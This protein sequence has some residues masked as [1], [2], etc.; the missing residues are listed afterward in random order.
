MLFN[1]SARQPRDARS[2]SQFFFTSLN[3]RHISLSC[4]PR[5]IRMFVNFRT[6][7]FSANATNFIFSFSYSAEFS[8]EYNI[9]RW[10]KIVFECSGQ[11]PFSWH[12]HNIRTSRT[13]SPR[14]VTAHSPPNVPFYIGKI[15]YHRMSARLLSLEKLLAYRLFFIF[16]SPFP[17]LWENRV[18]KLQV[19]LGTALICTPLP[20][21]SLPLLFMAVLPKGQSPPSQTHPPT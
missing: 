5:Y 16:I 13:L 20:P 15:V 4:V 2:H 10:R 21:I 9:F 19:W 18:W 7:L 3:F 6:K 1:F 8:Q 17:S 14:S 12:A 11:K